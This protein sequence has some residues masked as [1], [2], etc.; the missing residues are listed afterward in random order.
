MRRDAGFEVAFA[1]QAV[2]QS[3]W[4]PA[5]PATHPT[6]HPSLFSTTRPPPC[7]AFGLL[8]RRH[9]D[10]FA[11]RAD[12][13]AS[14]SFVVANLAPSFTVQVRVGVR[15]REAPPGGAAACQEFIWRCRRSPVALCS[16]PSLLSWRRP[17]CLPPSLPLQ[18]LSCTAL[19]CA[20]MGT[21]FRHALLPIMRTVVAE[22]L[23]QLAD[24]NLQ[25]GQARGSVWCGGRWS[26]LINMS[27]LHALPAGPPA[28]PLWPP[29]PLPPAASM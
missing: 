23:N 28:F 19:G 26:A 8:R 27:S 12:V 29:L 4:T 1:R 9:S 7:R 13:L 15:D 22:S 17:P 3:G 24:F 18:G 20:N 16:T 11:I 5:H 25:V 6:A 10:G 21:I 14:L 2:R